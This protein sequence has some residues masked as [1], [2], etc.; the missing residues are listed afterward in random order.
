M[1][2]PRT[3][4]LRGWPVRPGL[5]STSDPVIEDGPVERVFLEPAT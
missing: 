2:T 5:L 1:P 4:W 3:G